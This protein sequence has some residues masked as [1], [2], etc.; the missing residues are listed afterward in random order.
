MLSESS[1]IQKMQSKYKAL[2]RFIDLYEFIF[3][4]NKDKNPRY[5]LAKKIGNRNLRILD[6]C[7][8]TGN[9]SKAF[10]ETN[11]ITVG[12][13]LSH[14]M[15]AAA[16][17]KILRQNRQNVFAL[18]MDAANMGLQDEKFDV[19]MVSFG[20]HDME[21][22]LMLCVLEE[23]YRVLKKG[24]T[25]YIL[26]YEK[27][28]MLLRRLLFSIY[29]KISYPPHVQEFLKYDWNEIL[30]GIGF[31]MDSVETYTVSKMVSATK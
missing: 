15:L 20:L 27:E 22:D 3:L 8:G 19:I 5:S 29:L 9:G 17:R 31:Q 24:G 28:G 1:Y 4:F 6:V 14:D 26:D 30:K 13:D 7:F 16:K 12:V 18:Q 2:S 23:M 21:Y 10:W 25:L 11:N